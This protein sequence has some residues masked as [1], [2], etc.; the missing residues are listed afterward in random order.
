M[1]LNWNAEAV[2]DFDKIN[3]AQMWLACSTMMLVGVPRIETEEDARRCAARCEAYQKLHG[4]FGAEPDEETGR[5]RSVLITYDNFWHAFVGLR[6][7]VSS[8]TRTQFRTRLC[9]EE[10]ETW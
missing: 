10:F 5:S 1:P 8:M 3:E 6:T 9:A 2:K 4:N 7:N